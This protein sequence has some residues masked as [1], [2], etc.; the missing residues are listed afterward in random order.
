MFKIELVFDVNNIASSSRAVYF[1]SVF[2][3]EAIKQYLSHMKLT[4]TQWIVLF[5]VFFP[6]V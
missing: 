1:C 2:K 4:F 6:F 3:S 5:F